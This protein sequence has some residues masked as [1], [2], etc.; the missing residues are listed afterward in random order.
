MTGT[1]F[2]MGETVVVETEIEG[3]DTSI[4]DV[5][6]SISNSITGSYA[7]SGTVMEELGNQRYRYFWDTRIGYSAFSGWSSYSYY[8]NPSGITFP[9]IVSGW[10]GTSG[11]SVGISGLYTANIAARDSN[12]HYG[13]E[14]FKIRIG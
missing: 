9:Y 4:S 7:V 14:A 11:Y 1:T 12:N 5:N 8:T 2:K 13:T 3:V 10:S 6:I